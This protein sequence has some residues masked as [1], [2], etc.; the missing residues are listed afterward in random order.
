MNRPLDKS[1]IFSSYSQIRIHFHVA[2]PQACRETIAALAKLALLPGCV[3][4]ALTYWKQNVFQWSISG[5][6][7]SEADRDRHY[8]SDQIQV[9]FQGLIQQNASLIYCS[10][11][12]SGCPGPV[13]ISSGKRLFLVSQALKK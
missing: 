5:V 2:P 4:Y 10:E 6:W 1:I 13:N 3:E 11:G 9:L 12:Q 7:V 8:S